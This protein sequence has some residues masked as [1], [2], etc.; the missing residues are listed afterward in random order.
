MD[1][2]KK[3]NGKKHV[4]GSVDKNSAKLT[5]PPKKKK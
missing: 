2:N 4:Q 5:E 1:K 3:T